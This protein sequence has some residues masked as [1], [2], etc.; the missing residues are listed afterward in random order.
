MFDTTP[1][2]ETWRVLEK[3][4]EEKKLRAIGISTFR[5]DQIQDLYDKAKIKPHNLQIELH[6]YH[7]QQKLVDLCKKLNIR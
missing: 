3:F 2:I 4:Y 1:H 6:I 7:R 5:C